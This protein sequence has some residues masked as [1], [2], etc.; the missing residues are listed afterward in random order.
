MNAIEVVNLLKDKK[1]QHVQIAWQRMAKTFKV[2]GVMVGKTTVAWVRSGISYAN[3]ADVR[4]GIEKGEREPVQGLPWGQ[5]REGYANYIIDNG[6]QEYI[7]LYPA[8]FDNLKPTVQW[9]LEGI[10]TTYDKVE[11]YLLASEKRK[12]DEEKAACFTIRASDIVSVG[13]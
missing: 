6:E 13:N 7:R 4:E 11:P 10:P 1:G 8:S 12:E 2:A 5:W 9:T 3:L